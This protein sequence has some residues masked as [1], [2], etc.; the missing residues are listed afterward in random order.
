MHFKNTI[1]HPFQAPST[2]NNSSFDENLWENL[3]FFH[4]E[5][6]NPFPSALLLLLSAANIFDLKTSKELLLPNFS[7]YFKNGNL[8]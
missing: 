3:F 1:W 5:N 7:P 4:A 6:W 8:T 2:Y